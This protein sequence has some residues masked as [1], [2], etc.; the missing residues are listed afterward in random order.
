ME[1]PLVR[2]RVDD[3]RIAT[4]PEFGSNKLTIQ[5]LHYQI[6]RAV[7]IHTFSTKHQLVGDSPLI[8]LPRFMAIA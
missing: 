3:R 5:K 6:R 1:E 7:W 2:V 8:G 4:Y